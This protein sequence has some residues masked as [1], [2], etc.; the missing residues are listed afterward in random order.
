MCIPVHTHTQLEL[1][2][3]KEEVSR[4]QEENKYMLVGNIHTD[5]TSI[6]LM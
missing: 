4:L 1:S 2:Q 5:V 6:L 3:L